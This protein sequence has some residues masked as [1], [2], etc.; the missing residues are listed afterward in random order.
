MKKLILAMVLL[1][2]C[3]LLTA[4]GGPE[5]TYK[6]AQDLLA[7]GKFSE[8][9]AKFESIGSFEDASTLA[10]YCKACALCESGNFET[11][12]AALEKL[13]EYKDTPMRI[14]YYT[15]RSWDNNSVGTTEFEWMEKAKSIYNENPLYLDSMNRMTALD[16]RIVKAKED[17]YNAAIQNGENGK[18][19][20]A[21][22]AFS[23]LK[24]VNYKDSN[25]CYTYYSIRRD[26]DN[27]ASA[28]KQDSFASVASAYNNMKGFLDSTNR[29]A[30]LYVKADK[31]VADMYAQ[32]AAL[33][34][35]EKYADAENFL[36][37]FGTYGNDQ[38]TANYYT[39]AEKY[40]ALHNYDAASAAFKKA[41]NFKNASKWA[42]YCETRHYEEKANYANE[43]SMIK[44]QTLY[45]S[46]PGF[47]DSEERAAVLYQKRC[48]YFPDSVKSFNNGLARVEK[49]KK[50]GFVDTTGTLVIPCQWDDAGSFS[51]GLAQVEKDGKCGYIDTTGKLVIPCQWEYASSFSEGLAA[52]SKDGKY[53]FVDTTGKLV[54]PCQWR[55]AYGFSEGLAAVLNTNGK[56]GFVDTTGKLV[57]PCK[58]DNA[59]EFSEGLAY[60]WTGSFR[61]YKCGYIDTTGKLV[62]PC[63]WDSAYSFSDGL[64]EVKKDGKWGFIDTTG[65]L[66]IPYQWI[67]VDS[68]SNGVAKV[69]TSSRSRGPGND[70]YTYIDTTGKRVTPD[71]WYYAY[72]F[73]E[74]LAAVEDFG[75]WGFIDT[76]G[77]LVIPYQWDEAESFSEGLAWVKK[78]G[79]YD[80]IDTNGN[81]IL[82]IQ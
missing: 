65:K 76:T 16:E 28:T 67:S 26:E 43:Y 7:K 70:Q 47:E 5:A 62:I 52:V 14:T 12:I 66:V 58:W 75:K 81:S 29:A 31:I 6:S 51:E 36:S 78:D 11:G 80:I 48:I 32:I 8:A 19:N 4:C 49:D 10:I 38:V 9:A 53:G 74:G 57:I 79:K 22:D 46:I 34:A 41:G 63:Q 72:S 45:E 20:V 73:S 3:L 60:V 25:S 71:A 17:L 50:Y 13:G 24:S 39:I 21:L 82:G 69:C 68:F 77:K 56:Y 54:I 33:I 59:Y 42:I 61:D 64:A 30:A 35:E 2:S 1:L 37:S 27:L 55:Y 44:V 18:Y 15:A 40:L 23:R